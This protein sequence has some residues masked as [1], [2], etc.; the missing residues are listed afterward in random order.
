MRGAAQTMT[1]LRPR[2]AEEAV[3]L[4]A[5]TP[6]AVPL[7]GGTDFMVSWNAGH[8]NA[9]GDLNGAQYPAGD[10]RIACEHRGPD[11][12]G[13]DA[14]G[15]RRARARYVVLVCESWTDHQWHTQRLEEAFA[16]TGDE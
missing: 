3:Q 13:Q 15:L 9:S 1:L 16:D 12:M 10:R 11:A 2:A 4:L 14:D 6:D 5:A 8:A 7:A